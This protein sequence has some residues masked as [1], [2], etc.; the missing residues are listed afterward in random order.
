M[1]AMSMTYRVMLSKGQDKDAIKQAWRAFEGLEMLSV[2]TG[3]HPNYV[4]R[5]FCKIS[6]GD[7]GC[8]TS[9]DPSK[10]K[11]EILRG[12]F[13]LLLASYVML[14]GGS[15]SIILHDIT[16]ITFNHHTDIHPLSITYIGLDCTEDCW[17]NTHTPEFE[18]WYYKGDTSSDELC[19]H[20]AAYPM[21]YD[22]VAQTEGEKKR[23]LDMIEGITMGIIDN[24]L[25]FISP[26]TG[27]RT[28]WGFWVRDLIGLICS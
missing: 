2:V 17:Y 3:G 27:E 18:G 22:H 10:S 15:T 25:Y 7:N 21:L 14:S 26:E 1:S 24:D 13:S 8:P 12:H 9:I 16:R 20:M 5:S 23:V 28:T 6:D 19:G 4:A 11:Y